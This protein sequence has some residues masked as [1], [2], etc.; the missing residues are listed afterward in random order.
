MSEKAVEVAGW[1]PRSGWRPT[2]DRIAEDHLAG[3][4]VS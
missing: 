1:A 4:Q 2:K 3:Y